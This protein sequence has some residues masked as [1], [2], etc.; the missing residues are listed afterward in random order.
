MRVLLD[1]NAV[2]P[3]A[4]LP[5]AFE[6]LERGVND[7]ALEILFTHVTVDELALVPDPDRRSHLLVLLIA[8]GRLVPTGVC[9][10]DY[11]RVNFA[12]ISTDEVHAVWDVLRSASITHTRDAMIAGTAV[13]ERCALVTNDRRL[14]GRARACGV[15]VLSTTDLLAEFGFSAGQE[16]SA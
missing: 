14:T 10:A 6:A 8:L 5:G 7:G 13:F 2:D 12:R 3:M 4:D 9:V 1:S 16:R 11:S 15:E